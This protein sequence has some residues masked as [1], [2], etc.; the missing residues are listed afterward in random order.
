[1]KSHKSLMLLI[2]FEA[3]FGFLRH[4]RFRFKC[5]VSPLFNGQG[6]SRRAEMKRKCSM[7][8]S[9]FNLKGSSRHG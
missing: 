5:E 1:M 9:S 8:I 2:A 3:R 7:I 4:P 6:R